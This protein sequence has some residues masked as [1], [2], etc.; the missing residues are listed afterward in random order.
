MSLFTSLTLSINNRNNH[1]YNI[2][3]KNTYDIKKTIFCDKDDH[4]FFSWEK[5]EKGSLVTLC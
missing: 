1:T 5:K 2:F 4:E 3:G